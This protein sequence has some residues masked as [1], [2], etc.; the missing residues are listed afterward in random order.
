MNT[1]KSIKPNEIVYLEADQNYSILHFKNG[2]KSV[3]AFTLKYLHNKV[4]INHFLR[5][6]RSF[7]LNPN[8]ILDIYKVGPIIFIKMSDGKEMQVSRRKKML[9]E[10]L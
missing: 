1:A 7:L 9:I 8:Y 3:S 10:N 5:I 4:E 2:R 6:N